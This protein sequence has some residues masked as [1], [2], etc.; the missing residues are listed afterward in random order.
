MKKLSV[1]LLLIA[2]VTSGC[3]HLHTY[4]SGKLKQVSMSQGSGSKKF[5]VEKKWINM[6]VG[7]L[8]GNEV[9]VDELIVK[10]IGPGKTIS[11]VKVDTKMSFLNGLV[12]FFTFNIYTPFSMEIT[13]TYK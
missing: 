9:D 7:G 11:N 2:I 10:E 4:S 6:F 1:V 3:F 8:V 12:S 13:G 5:T